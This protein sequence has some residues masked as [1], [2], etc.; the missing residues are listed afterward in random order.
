MPIE[1]FS[2]FSSKCPWCLGLHPV[3]FRLCIWCWWINWPFFSNFKR[4]FPRF[5]GRKRRR[6]QVT[7]PQNKGLRIHREKPDDLPRV[8]IGLLKKKQ[9]WGKVYIYIYIYDPG[10]RFPTPPTPPQCDDPVHTTH[11]SNDYMA[12]ALLLWR[13][14]GRNR[15]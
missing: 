14:V 11:C 5:G 15:I 4:E 9:F 13:W 8:R 7:K 6:S 3:Q 10:L 12:A 2:N 1:D